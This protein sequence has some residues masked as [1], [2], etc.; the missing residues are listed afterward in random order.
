ME[1]KE[2]ISKIVDSNNDEFYM[3]Y[4]FFNTL[5][6]WF[7]TKERKYIDDLK[8]IMLVWNSKKYV[9]ILNEIRNPQSSR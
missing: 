5:Y 8:K 6:Q 3:E 7:E 9:Q 1:K 4:L 2:E